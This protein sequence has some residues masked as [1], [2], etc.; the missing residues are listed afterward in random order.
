VLIGKYSIVI[1]NRQ[2]EQLC[3]IS[4]TVRIKSGAWDIS[5]IGDTENELFVYTTLHHIK[6][7]L[8]CG[9]LG[10]IRTI[11]NPIYI[12]RVVT[13][14]LFCLDREERVKVISIDTT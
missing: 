6:Y 3:S 8:P 14:Q 11:E 10:T 1:A 4:D 7:C 2:L 9:D 5:P 13:D 12:Q